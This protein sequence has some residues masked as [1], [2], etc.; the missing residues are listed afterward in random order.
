M[1]INPQTYM[2]VV[3]KEP[4]ASV[5]VKSS[6]QASLLIVFVSRLLRKAVSGLVFGRYVFDNRS[7]CHLS[8]HSTWQLC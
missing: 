5:L 1:S 7:R 3:D 8:S 4:L 6:V 2:K